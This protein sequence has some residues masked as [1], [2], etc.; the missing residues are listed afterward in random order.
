MLQE[1]GHLDEQRLEQLYLALAEVAGTPREE[2]VDLP[3]V[4]RV[5]AAVLFGAGEE[6]SDTLVEDWPLL[7]S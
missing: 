7:F 6:P 1:F 2:P 5:A 4:R 3:T